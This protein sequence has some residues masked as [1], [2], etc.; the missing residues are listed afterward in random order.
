MLSPKL[1]RE[2]LKNLHR[3]NRATW[4]TGGILA[5]I[6]AGY[7]FIPRGIRAQLTQPLLAGVTVGLGYIGLQTKDAEAERRSLG[8]LYSPED[9][10]QFPNF[11]VVEQNIRGASPADYVDVIKG[12]VHDEV[13][14]TVTRV[15]ADK[16]G[17]VVTDKLKI[18]DF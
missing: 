1:A 11:D 6:V 5:A 7:S 10:H 16:V 4:I 15:V 8:D 2:G 18:L 14:H 12:A 3:A 13:E 9:D 17:S